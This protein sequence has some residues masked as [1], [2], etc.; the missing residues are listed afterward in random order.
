MNERVLITGAQGFLGRYVTAAILKADSNCEVIGIGRS[1]RSDDSFTHTLHIKDGQ[2]IPA[3]LPLA[4]RNIFTER[5]RYLSVDI[6]S[7]AQI[8]EL[9]QAYRPS[10]IIHLASGLRGDSCSKLFNTNISG[11][12][13]LMSAC[14]AYDYTGSF[15]SVS[16]GGVYGFPSKPGDLPFLESH[17][18]N[19]ED[20][21]QLT[22]AAEETIVKE[23][24]EYLAIPWMILRVFNVIGPGQDERH[25]CGRFV[26]ELVRI[27][28]EYKDAY[29][30]TSAL[31][32]V[33]DFV[34]V[35][36]VASN[37]VGLFMNKQYKNVFNI[38][39]GKPAEIA[40]VLNS[41]L[42]AVFGAEI[43][44][45]KIDSVQT[46]ETVSKQIDHHFGDNCKLLSFGGSVNFSLEN[47]IRDMVAYYD[48]VYTKH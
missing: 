6:N 38:S 1:G 41:C 16:S 36:D 2:N 39:S 3:P 35:R 29:L 31:T 25:V 22:K 10:A 19:P 13:N 14:R 40:V 27:K 24:C 48:S 43:G 44:H 21:Y 5:Y 33:R 7:K 34:D 42:A 11:M 8:D 37:I 23:F 4:L 28:N 26:S 46:D 20:S 18:C 30:K 32:S 9:F 45:L 12:L 47:S 17:P 15:I